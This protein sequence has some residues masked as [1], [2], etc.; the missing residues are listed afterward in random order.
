MFSAEA[1]QRGCST[2]AGR[3]GGWLRH[4]E[5]QPGPAEVAQRQAF[6][7]ARF[8][9]VVDFKSELC[10]ESAACPWVLV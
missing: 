4:S 5:Q 9:K 2:Q 6:T 3:L 8:Q 1:P 7:H 10:S